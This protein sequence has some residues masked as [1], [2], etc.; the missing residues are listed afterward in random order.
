MI[1]IFLYYLKITH[2]KIQIYKFYHFLKIQIHFRIEIMDAFNF[3]KFFL[4]NDKNT[5]FLKLNCIINIQDLQKD[6]S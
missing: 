4:I 2:Y 3:H 1:N 6:F 5:L